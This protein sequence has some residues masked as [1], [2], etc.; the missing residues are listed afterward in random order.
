MAEVWP[1]LPLNEI[2]EG[3][4]WLTEVDQR[5][6]DESRWAFRVARQTFD[7]SFRMTTGRYLEAK[8]LLESNISGDWLVPVWADA[9]RV[10]VTPGDEEIDVD[11][12]AEFFVGGK[13]II[14]VDCETWEIADVVDITPA[15]LV[16]YPAP[17]LGGS[18]LV[19]PLRAALIREAVKVKRSMRQT[20]EL[21]IVFE[22][23]DNPDGR[24]IVEP[25]A[26]TISI[27]VSTSMK[28]ASP[29]E[30]VDC[31]TLA[32]ANALAI[33]D[34][35]EATGVSHDVR[36]IL[37][38]GGHMT[39]THVACD[40]AGYA[41]LRDFVTGADNFG[42]SIWELAFSGVESF[43]VNDGR[44]VMFLIS[45][46]GASIGI[47]DAQDRR[48]SID[49]LEVFG[50]MVSGGA[51]TYLDQIDNTDGADLVV[52]DGDG[53]TFAMLTLLEL[54]SLDLVP[55][56]VCGGAVVEAQSGQIM[57]VTSYVDSSLGPVLPVTERNVVEAIRS[58]TI[59]HA[60]RGEAWQTKRLLAY[61]Q[62]R[63]LP[64]Y[65]ADFSLPTIGFTTSSIRI[66]TSYA[67]AVASW[68]GQIVN[69][70]GLLREI[71][72]AGIVTGAIEL[73]FRPVPSLPVSRELRVVRRVRLYSDDME[74]Q[75][76][77]GAGW[78]KVAIEAGEN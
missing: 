5:R 76:H 15:G 8:R 55:F 67:G 70:G 73:T 69:V 72:T 28:D 23:Q 19:L 9:S 29:I 43:Y 6:D 58:T 39:E 31:F 64:F 50:V 10:L 16:I 21:S 75:W 33:L 52:E 45:D 62:G 27:D 42:G 46:V 51:T 14:W 1:Y 56:L 12:R 49:R 61:V 34:Y 48:D 35:L 3:L 66:A 68:A 41:S 32:K 59:R 65:V 30:G 26:V 60:D 24:Y 2:T 20:W 44:R 25:M 74:L 22:S 36:V 7:L 4:S 37:Y 57:R 54:E 17:E 78:L 13:A 63:S 40:A 11:L 18:L 77:R 47:S 38:W 53:T 71:E